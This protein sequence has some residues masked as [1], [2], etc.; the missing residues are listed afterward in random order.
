MKMSS[1]IKI[2]ELTGDLAGQEAGPEEENRRRDR[3]DGRG[4][5]RVGV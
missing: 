4:V 3:P 1:N 5:L 2:G